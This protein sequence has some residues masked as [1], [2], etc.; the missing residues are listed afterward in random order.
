MPK[1]VGCI[2]YFKKNQIAESIFNKA[3]TLKGEYDKVGFVRLNN[4]ENEEPL[5]S[6]AMA[7]NGETPIPND[8]S[9][10]ADMMYY[11]KITSNVITGKA[12]LTN[13]NYNKTNGEDIPAKCYPA[14]VHFNGLYTYEYCY[15]IEVYRLNHLNQHRLLLQIISWTMLTLPHKIKINMKSIFRPAY[16]LLFGYRKILINVRGE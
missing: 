8:G 9:I 14:I 7:I 11:K 1:F 13:A 2:Y 5:I 15:E 3:I 16:R 6:V 10:K 4:K 12:I